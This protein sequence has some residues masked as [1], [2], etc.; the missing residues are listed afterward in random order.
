[1]LTI[2]YDESATRKTNFYE[3]TRVLKI[4][5]KSLKMATDPEA[6]DGRKWSENLYQVHGILTNT[7]CEPIRSSV[8]ALQSSSVKIIGSNNLYQIAIMESAMSKA[9]I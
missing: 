6:P 3:A 1:M 4:F 8:W 5:A 2:A 7:Y 9:I